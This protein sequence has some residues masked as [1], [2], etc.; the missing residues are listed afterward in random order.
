MLLINLYFNI[1]FIYFFKNFTC[2]SSCTARVDGNIKGGIASANTSGQMDTVNITVESLA[3][4]NTI[5]RFVKLDGHLHQILLALNVEAGDLGHIRLSAW[6]GFLGGG[7]AWLHI[8]RLGNWLCRY[9]SVGLLRRR[10]LHNRLVVGGLG[11]LWTRLRLVLWRRPWLRLVLGWRGT[12]FGLVLWGRTG[13][14]LVL[15]WWWQR[16]L[17]G[18]RWS[19]LGLADWP[20]WG[21][22]LVA[23]LGPGG[24]DNRSRPDWHRQRYRDGLGRGR[25]VVGYRRGLGCS[26]FINSRGSRC[27]LGSRVGI[28]S[29]SGNIVSMSTST[30]STSA[31]STSTVSTSAVVSA[32]MVAAGTVSVLGNLVLRGNLALFG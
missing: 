11:L 2:V 22:W 15:G 1:F 13:L 16:L 17:L 12:R 31:V 14:R 28:A 9:R 8:A 18:W 32:M 4:D 24:N 26:I 3:K 19:V 25:L 10:S 23:W 30:V 29:G 7:L 20:L 27:S 6:P 21:R 5:E